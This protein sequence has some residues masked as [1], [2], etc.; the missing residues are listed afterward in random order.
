MSKVIT[1]ITMP[2]R[3]DSLPKELIAY[4][5]TVSEATTVLKLSATCHKLRAACWDALVFKNLLLA[6]QHNYWQS[7]SLDV[8]AI[9]DLAGND[10]IVWAKYCIADERARHLVEDEDSLPSPKTFI[11]YLPDLFTVK[12]P[13]MTSQHWK[14][15]L[16]YRLDQGSSQIFCIATT[17]L[18]SNEHLPSLN[19]S[20]KLEGGW[21]LR[22]NTSPTGSLW[23]L[24]M[25]ALIVRRGVKTRL[26]A[27]PF[28]DAA[29]VPHIHPPTLKQIPMRLVSDK[30]HLP[31]P[32]SR[33]SIELLGKSTSS[34]GAWDSWYSLH[35]VESL[36]SSNYLTKGPWCGYYIRFGDD[37][38]GPLNPPMVDINFELVADPGSDAGDNADDSTRQKLRAKDC[39]DGLDSFEITGTVSWDVYGVTLRAR[40]EYQNRGHGWDWDCQLTPFGLVG[41]WGLRNHQMPALRREGIV[42]LWREEWTSPT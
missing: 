19:K 5:A 37:P 30:Y 36:K 23:G 28:N 11:S 26:A 7:D 24:C 27:W 35:N 1:N 10:T 14:D 41:Y 6:S 42:W 34:F 22:D 31:L 38:L 2:T 32:F 39:L 25:I 21:N 18:A 40:K 9:A 13:F 12:H 17:I 16:R 20:L 8:E 33:K 29:Q 15:T 4:I 3:L